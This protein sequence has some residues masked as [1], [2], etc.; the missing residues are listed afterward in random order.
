LLAASALAQVPADN[1]PQPTVRVTTGLVLVDA[2]V[3]D[4]EG[5]PVRDLKPEDFQVYENGKLVKLAFVTLHSPAE[6]RGTE[7]PALPPNV[8]TN[9]PQYRAAT[10]PLIL[11]VLDALNTPAQDQAYARL[12]LLKYLETQLKPEQP[13][14]VYALGSS[15]R[16]LQDFTD[17][18]GHLH[19]AVEAFRPEPSRALSME[20][21]P[22]PPAPR[23]SRFLKLN[24]QLREFYVEQTE[25]A[26]NLRVLGTLTAL[27]AIGR[28]MAGLSGRKNL[29]WVTAA[30][31]L[32]SI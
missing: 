18:P 27:R 4:R 3:T 16:L 21:R 29:I 32:Q 28:S 11:L 25:A 14:A 20:D 1:I 6:T 24:Q 23:E 2:V 7:G 19:A 22:A 26:L 17:D 13:V 5:R 30:F 15:L 10:E 12:Q 31:P 9:R 8:Y